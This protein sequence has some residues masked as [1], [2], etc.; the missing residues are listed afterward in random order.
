MRRFVKKKIG[1]SE[2]LNIQLN[3][4]AKHGDSRVIVFRVFAKSKVINMDSN[5]N[6]V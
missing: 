3:R 2:Q 1:F 4:K 5:V 6:N